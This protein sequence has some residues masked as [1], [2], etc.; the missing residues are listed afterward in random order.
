MVNNVSK[1]RSDSDQFFVVFASP[2]IL[3]ISATMGIQC[4]GRMVL[5]PNYVCMLGFRTPPSLW[6]LSP[7]LLYA[8]PHQILDFSVLPP[9]VWVLNASLITSTHSKQD[10]NS[11]PNVFFFVTVNHFS[12]SSNMRLT[13][14][15]PKAVLFD[16]HTR[17]NLRSRYCRLINGYVSIGD[18]MFLW[19]CTFQGGREQ[20][21]GH[22]TPGVM[23]F[24]QFRVTQT[25]GQVT[26]LHDSPR[27]E[28]VFIDMNLYLK[29][30]AL[31]IS[32]DRFNSCVPQAR[33]LF[34]PTWSLNHAVY[35]M[36]KAHPY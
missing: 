33:C 3:L 5:G 2:H 4:S 1:M 19:A 24:Q 8:T 7:R 20:G 9:T 27:S 21:G 26:M 36:C 6:C 29:R 12:Q 11:N 23:M 31:P 25:F 16:L 30:D 18:F 10:R 22:T 34:R 17:K 14:T 13:T 28:E 35:L 15:L 32:L